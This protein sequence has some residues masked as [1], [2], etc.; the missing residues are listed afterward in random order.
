[1]EFN[2][3]GIP[4][5][6]DIWVDGRH[7]VTWNGRYFSARVM[8]G[9]G[10][11]ASNLSSTVH[12]P[13]MGQLKINVVAWHEQ[14]EEERREE[15]VRRAFKKNPILVPAIF[16]TE[17][18]QVRGRHAGDPSKMLITYDNGQKDNVE[19]SRLY[20]IR[21]DLGRLQALYEQHR[22]L[23]D[24]MDDLE[25]SFYE[26]D[27]IDLTGEIRYRSDTDDFAGMVTYEGVN[28]HSV[29]NDI[30]EVNKEL[31][32]M[33]KIHIFPWAVEEDEVVSSTQVQ[34]GD[35]FKTKEDAEAWLALRERRGEVMDEI[36]AISISFD[37][38]AELKTVMDA[39]D[40]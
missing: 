25:H 5:D 36:N 4:E 17:I 9:R 11:A 10:A 34:W 6:S 1:M 20:S 12:A 2:I 39:R 8:E 24:Q 23:T 14:K 21:S 40:E 37:Y 38:D 19:R 3:T 29:H 28:F 13:N 26:V 16:R 32:R 15:A 33:V 22:I 30:L 31:D 18:I 27:R 35:V 7:R